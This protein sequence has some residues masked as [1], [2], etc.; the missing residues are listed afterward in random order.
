MNLSRKKSN[1]VPGFSFLLSF[2]FL[3]FIKEAAV[4]CSDPFSFYLVY[5]GKVEAL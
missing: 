1:T 2:S 3:F 5:V 4:S